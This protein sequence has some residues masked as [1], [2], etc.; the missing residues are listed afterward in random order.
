MLGLSPSRIPVRGLVLLAGAGGLVAGCGSSKDN[1]ASADMAAP[2]PDMSLA[3]C[4]PFTPAPECRPG[5]LTVT[6]LSG[7]RQ[8]LVSSLKIAKFSEGFDLNCDGVPD[9]KL[10]AIGGLANSQIKTS[11]TSKHDIVLPIELFGYTGAPTD[12]AKFAFYLGRVV[13]DK[14]GDGYTTTWEAGRADCDDTRGD[15]HPGATDV[16]GGRVDLDCDGYAG[17]PMPG[18]PPT[19]TM[20]LDGDGYTLAQGDCDDDPTDPN[21]KN[22]H[23]G[24]AEICGNGIDE[25][26]DGIADDGAACDPFGEGDANVHVQ[27]VS[28]SNPPVDAGA[29][30]FPPAG[31]KP[32]IVFPDGKITSGACPA[33]SLPADLGITSCNLL[34]A[35]PDLFELKL[36]I[37]GFS[38]DLKLTGAHVSMAFAEEASGTHLVDGLLGGV[39]QDSTLAQVHI[40]AGGILSKDQSLLDGIY[41]GPAATILGLATDPQGH[42]LPDIDVD[43]D[44]LETFWDSTAGNNSGDAGAHVA[45]VDTCQDGDGTILHNSDPGI[46]L[47]PNTGTPYCPLAKNADGS[48]RFV[49]GLSAALRFTAVPAKITDIVEQ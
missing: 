6:P 4:K 7:S 45:R 47:D 18:V 3:N 1:G 20:D 39:L 41:A 11:F 25:D 31:L 8:L 43:G 36:D 27:T 24:A 46:P 26:C 34:T 15:V 40:D 13:E 37:Q 22:R 48:F 10:S 30:P 33:G 32:Y 14:D 2:A 17:N 38:L 16:A 23:P 49:D 5:D 35:G 44:G 28:F 19:D 9:N 42:Y 12:C 29:G 21:A